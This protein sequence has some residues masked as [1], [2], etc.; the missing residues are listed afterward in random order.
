MAGAPSDRRIS[1]LV[2]VVR[3]QQDNAS[4]LDYFL[5]P[6]KRVPKGRLTFRRTRRAQLQRFRMTELVP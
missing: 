2:L 1:K 6:Q 4:V 3:L 5:M